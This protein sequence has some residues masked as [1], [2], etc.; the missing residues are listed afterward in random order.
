MRRLSLFIGL[1]LLGFLI[2]IVPL[3]AE[4]AH[5]QR[6]EELQKALSDISSISGDFVQSKKMD[7]LSEPLVSGG[8]F[9]FARPDYLRW[10]YLSP[11]P[12]GLIID[13]GQVQA[14]T[15]PPSAKVRQPEAMAEASRMVAG[16]VM[17]WM[18]MEPEAIRAAYEVSVIG[19][20]PLKLKVV[21]KRGGAR[22][23]LKHLEVE[24][25]TDGRTVRRVILQEAESRTTLTFERV[26]LNRPRPAE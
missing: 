18:K 21:P 10:E 5:L 19:E 3:S 6:L 24:F 11:A 7:F 16:Q 15:G 17:L 1:A 9:H 26:A 4:P 20:R 14:W 22:K 23:F 8:R 12:S 13:G 2:R 25:N